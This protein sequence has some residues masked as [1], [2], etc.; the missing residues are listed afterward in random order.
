MSRRTLS[1]CALALLAGLTTSSGMASA[2]GLEAI[3]EAVGNALEISS[4]AA[5]FILGVALIVS[6]TIAMAMAGVPFEGMGVVQVG[7]VGAFTIVGWLQPWILVMSCIIVAALLG[8]K[9]KG[10]LSSG[11]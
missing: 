3:P 4:E 11:G 7:L 6:V 8:L 1:L 2:G 5:G 9:A 10:A